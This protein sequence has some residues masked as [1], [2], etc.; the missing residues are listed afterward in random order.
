MPGSHSAGMNSQHLL[1]SLPNLLTSSWRRRILIHLSR[2]HGLDFS[3]DLKFGVISTAPEYLK[4]FLFIYVMTFLRFS[5]CLCVCLSVSVSSVSVY[6]NMPQQACRSQS[7]PHGCGSFLSTR[8]PR[9]QKQ[10]PLPAEPSPRPGIW[11]LFA[12]VIFSNV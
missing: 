4:K 2:A 10:V 8:G 9:A 3:W 5:V 6:T 12:P 1:C 11:I 7:R